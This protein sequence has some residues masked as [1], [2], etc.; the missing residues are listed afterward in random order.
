M[1]VSTPGSPSVRRSRRSSF[2]GPR[3]WSVPGPWSILGPSV[4]GPGTQDQGRTT[5]PG[6]DKEPGYQARRTAL[7][8]IGKRSLEAIPHDQ[9]RV[10]VVLVLAEK[11]GRLACQEH[12]A[13]RG[14][15]VGAVGL[16]VLGL[17]VHAAAVLP[18]R[19]FGRN[20]SRRTERIRRAA[21]D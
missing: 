16:R 9:R 20:A 3:S 21:D 8:R 5:G 2:L 11:V 4:R 15:P 12:A 7:H 13:H 6:T 18:N 10:R 14:A 1:V 19:S 17:R